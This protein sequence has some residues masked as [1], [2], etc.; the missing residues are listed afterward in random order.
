MLVG[1]YGGGPMSNYSDDDPTYRYTAPGIA[2][3]HTLADAINHGSPK[4]RR[5]AKM[6]MAFWAVLIALTLVPLVISAL[7]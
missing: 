5:R 1:D 3:A 7:T 4:A 2:S 6:L